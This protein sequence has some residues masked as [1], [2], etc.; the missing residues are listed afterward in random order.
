[1]VEELL[2]KP[3]VLTFIQAA[4]GSTCIIVFRFWSL[5]ALSHTWA[6]PIA[7]VTL[8]LRAQQKL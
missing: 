2:S 4:V 3:L 6:R 8:V 7:L 5:P 1:M